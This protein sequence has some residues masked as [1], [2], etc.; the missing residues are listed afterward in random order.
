VKEGTGKVTLRLKKWYDS[1]TWRHL[2]DTGAHPA[3]EQIASA[4]AKSGVETKHTTQ[5][6]EKMAAEMGK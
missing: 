4:M 3:Q 2:I 6:I 1:T 5:D